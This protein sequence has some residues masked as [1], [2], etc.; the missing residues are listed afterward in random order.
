[1][2]CDPENGWN[3]IITEAQMRV[4]GQACPAMGDGPAEGDLLGRGDARRQAGGALFRCAVHRL[5]RRLGHRDRPIHKTE[6]SG[7]YVWDAEIKDYETDL[8]KLHAPRFEIDWKTTR[9]CLADCPSLARHLLTARRSGVWW[10]SL[11]V[12]CPA[13]TYRGL[14]NML[15]DF[16]ENPEG[17]KELLAMISA[18]SPREARLSRIAWS[19]EPEQRRHVRGIGRIRLHRRAARRPI[20]AGRVAARDLWGFTESQETVDVS[21]E[22][23]E[24]FIFPY[25]KPI[26]ERFGLNCYGCCEPLHGRWPAVARHH[27]SP[28]RVLFALGR[29]GEDGRLS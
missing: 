19:A 16:I 4:P 20:S 24:E 1:M 2:F 27:A 23:Y 25:E 15:C 22:M 28:P 3:E 17:L 26:M 5:A 18:R 21:P 6:T 8:R 9:G 12:T 13:A 7:S 14:Q 29:P 11:G 10:W